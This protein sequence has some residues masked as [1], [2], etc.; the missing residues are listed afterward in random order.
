MEQRFGGD[1][2]G[3]GSFDQA[4]YI[5]VP[6][7]YEHTVSY[8][9][10]TG[11]GPAA[12][13]R[14]SC[15]LEFF[16]EETQRPYWS[17]NSVHTVSTLVLREDPRAAIDQIRDQVGVIVDAGKFPLTLGGEHTISSGPVEALAARRPDFGVLFI[18]AHLD[19]RAEY[20]GTPWSHA[21]VA[22]RIHEG[23]G[24]PMAWVGIRSVAAEEHRYLEAHSELVISYAHEEDRSGE[25]FDRVLA[26]LPER[27]YLS[28][29]V[30]GLDPSVIPGT[31]TPEPGGL[32][33]REVLRL[34]RR[35]SQEKTLV[36]ADV[37]ELA[38]IPH[39]QVSE[40]ATAKLMAKIIAAA[41]GS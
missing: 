11:D 17:E 29:D 39:Q 25:G 30:D 2:A 12:I 1:E 7:P 24:L 21:C 9:G 20:G 41:P 14:A 36:G 16:N 40:F 5:V 31:G 23:L 32:A 6:A 15:E 37:V 33:Y 28:L 10:G 26:A 34:I 3:L 18:D 4:Q 35:L 13:L 22:R 38:P 8:G 27:V 19:L